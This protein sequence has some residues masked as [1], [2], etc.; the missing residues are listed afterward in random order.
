ML[1]A[2]FTTVDWA[3]E[4]V[5]QD[6][7][8]S[9]FYRFDKN[10]QFVVNG[11]S[12]YFIKDNLPRRLKVWQ[13]AKAY[14]HK[15][16]EIIQATTIN[17]LHLHNPN[18]VISNH[19][20]RRLNPDLPN[21]I[22]DHSGVY[23]SKYRWL[24]QRY[25]KDIGG[26]VFAAKGQELAYVSNKIVTQDQCHFVMENSS[27]FKYRDRVTARKKTKIT[28]NPVFL[29]IGNLNKN[30]DPFAVLNA[31]EQFLDYK[32]DATLYMI[33]RYNDLEHEV[34][35]KIEKTAQLCKS[36]FLLGSK[37]RAELDF[38]Y[39]SAD[40][41]VSGSHKEGSGYAMIE[42]MSCGVIPIVTD[43]PSFQSLTQ[44]G[45]I[46]RLWEVGNRN[47]LVTKM[48]E[49]V[50]LPIEHESVKTLTLF[51]ER[52]SFKAI[53]LQMKSIYQNVSSQKRGK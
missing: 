32:P 37:E 22:Q 47:D 51:N 28:G 9:V 4:M 3:E 25:L 1:D 27:K 14:S 43:I 11:V 33:Y 16:T 8:V 42:A 34:K 35:L 39:N 10:E 48:L 7:E 26:I 31:F 24:H 49:I 45:R 15:I 41:F 53:I 38:F 21:I 13:N 17:F 2:F 46:G 29:W 12:Y 5:R 50:E 20:L 52:F 18:N 40:Y 19:Y 23:N 6:M 44:N 30:K 36:V